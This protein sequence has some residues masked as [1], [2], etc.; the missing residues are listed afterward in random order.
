MLCG[1]PLPPVLWVST[2]S[3]T[4]ATHHL[5]CIIVIIIVSISGLLSP[6]SNLASS[7]PLSRLCQII[8]YLGISD[9]NGALHTEHSSAGDITLRINSWPHL[10]LHCIVVEEYPMFVT[11]PLER[12]ARKHF[13]EEKVAF[14]F[15]F[16]TDSTSRKQ[17]Q[18]STWDLP[19][20]SSSSCQTG[21]GGGSGDSNL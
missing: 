2:P 8:S 12:K 3:S 14:V 5:K 18:L 13:S 11:V 21:G 6:S 9:P 19:S 17:T 16:V 10:R 1:Y 4:T 7:H 15:I 20:N